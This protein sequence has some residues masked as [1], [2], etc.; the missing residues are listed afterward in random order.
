MN[1]R[2]FRSILLVAGVVLLAS[3]LIILDCLYG[4]FENLQE[5]QL[6][7]ELSLAVSAVEEEGESYLSRLKPESYRLTWIGEDGSVLYTLEIDAGTAVTAG[8]S[9]T[10]HLWVSH[11]EYDRRDET[12]EGEEWLVTVTPKA[13]EEKGE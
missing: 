8:E 10:L 2:I 11:W 6:R 12:Y 3:F 4:Y 7:D 1:K 9:Y 13:A 5:D